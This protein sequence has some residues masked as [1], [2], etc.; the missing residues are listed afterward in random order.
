MRPQALEKALLTFHTN[1]MADINKI[2][3]EL[4][5]K[6]YRNQDID[7]IQACS[8]SVCSVPEV[9]G[10]RAEVCVMLLCD[11]LCQATAV[12]RSSMA[13]CSCAM[14]AS[15]ARPADSPAHKPA[16]LPD[17]SAPGLPPQHRLLCGPVCSC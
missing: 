2:I 1:K 8:C 3:K 13:Q 15:C 6:T 12:S 17:R 5:Q 10:C 11:V 4:W 7:Y 14:P 16:W 9:Q